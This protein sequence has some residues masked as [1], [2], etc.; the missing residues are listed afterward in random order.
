MPAGSS[1]RSAVRASAV[2][3]AV[4]FPRCMALL[5]SADTV[6]T[7]TMDGTDVAN[8]PLVK[9]YNPIQATK[10]VFSAGTIHALYN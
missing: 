6:A 1:T 2:T 7:V 10:V 9:G 3:T 5:C 8:F 4:E